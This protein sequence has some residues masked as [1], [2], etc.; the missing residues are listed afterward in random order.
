MKL[1]ILGAGESGVGAALLAKAKGLDVFVSDMGQIKEV[2]K[3]KLATAAIP[4]EEGTHTF[5]RILESN[6]IIKSP[7]IPDKATIIQEAIKKEIPVISEIEFA[8]RYT[9]A[10]FICITGT[11]G[12]TTTT[13]LTYH[14]LKSAGINVGLAGNI[15]ESLAEKVIDNKHEYYVVELSSFQLDNMYQF[16]A[17]IGVLLNITPDHL[18][19]YGYDLNK[20]AASKLRI[21]QNMSG[22]DYF[23]YNND[24]DIIRNAFDSA[25]FGG[26]TIPF[27]LQGAAGT[28]VLCEGTHVKVNV[29]FF[30]G[31]IDASRS[32]LIGKHNQYNTMAAVAVAKLMG[33]EDSQIEKGLETFE[34]AEHRLQV[35]T[36]SK[37]VTYINDSKATNVEAVYYALE[38]IKQPIIWIAGGVD[39]GNDYSALQDLAKEKVKVL[40]CL[41][42]DNDKL[43]EAF[44]RIVPVVVETTS[45]EYAVR[46]GRLLSTPGDVVLLSPACASFD[47]FNN[48]EHRGQRFREAVEKIVLKK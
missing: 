33:V 13:L 9:D 3:A 4:Y 40:V 41:G 36:V 20:Y 10:K 17:H 28:K 21:A 18:D 29:K 44:G 12:K 5:E 6:E 34:N 48:Y 39:K 22:A 31:D 15:G 35:I 27:S 46:M 26:T 45:M 2:Y 43:K 8:G 14:L 16:K 37:E 23:I 42:K 32:A 38:G 24:D 11:N 1:A 30:E 7:G 47:L 25:S 19:R